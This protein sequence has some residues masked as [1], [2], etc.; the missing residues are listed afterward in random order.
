MSKSKLVSVIM[1]IYNTRPDYLNTAISSVAMQQ[2]IDLR[3]ME[4]VMID[5]FSGPAYQ[6]E[7]E[8]VVK[9]LRALYPNL[10]ILLDSN[11]HEKGAGNARNT[12]ISISNG[13]YIS[14]LDSDD[15][16]LPDAIEKSCSEME[17]SDQIFVTFSDH[18]K[19]D[20][21]L[22]NP[23]YKRNKRDL[24]LLHGLYK[25]TLKDPLLHM[26]FTG[27]L[28]TLRREIIEAIGG[29]MNHKI[30][31]DFNLLLRLSH[32]S[33]ETNF[34][35]IPESLYLYRSNPD[36]LT[37]KKDETIKYVEEMLFPT[38]IELGHDISAIKFFDEVKPRYNFYDIFDAN[39]DL[40]DVPWLDRE[41]KSII[42]H[43]EIP[44][45]ETL[46]PITEQPTH[47]YAGGRQ[48]I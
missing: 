40:V 26:L 18:I 15:A 21:N 41:S 2:G 10:S 31:E 39:G 29:Y 44:R 30:G 35:H 33:P 38:L 6:R 32:L 3:D 20:E 22:T 9:E 43:Q 47:A 23:I 12:G 25:N 48:G 7:T 28:K 45:A 5:D 27:P 34:S 46:P 14:L 4:L 24:F 16:L 19:T 1:P 17:K 13:K 37:S 8:C 42:P 11:H 36:S